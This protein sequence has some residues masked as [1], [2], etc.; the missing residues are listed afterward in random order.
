[1][2]KSQIQQKNI[3]FDVIKQNKITD[4][5]RYLDDGMPAKLLTRDMLKKM[6]DGAVA[7][8]SKGWRKAMRENKEIK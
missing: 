5:L 7:I 2:Q 3:I 8:D 4:R 6:K 1:M